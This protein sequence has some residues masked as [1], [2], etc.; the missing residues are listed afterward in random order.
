MGMSNTERNVEGRIT[1]NHIG[2]WYIKGED[3]FGFQN[4]YSFDSQ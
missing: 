4:K 3:L 1:V 2:I